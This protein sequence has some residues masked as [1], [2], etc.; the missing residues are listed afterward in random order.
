M[1]MALDA[2][3]RVIGHLN[4]LCAVLA[5]ALLFGIAAIICF[6]VLGRAGVRL[7]LVP[8]PTRAQI[9]AAALDPSGQLSAREVVAGTVVSLR[10]QSGDIEVRRPG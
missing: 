7:L 4:L 2:V 8:H 3:R 9:A 1:S 10:A 5:A 6:E